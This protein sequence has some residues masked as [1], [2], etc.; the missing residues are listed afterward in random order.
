MSKE[1]KQVQALI[2]E[3]LL[4]QENNYMG[5]PD[6]FSI[7]SNN[8]C[9]R[10]K[11]LINPKMIVPF[12][13][14]HLML[15]LCYGVPIVFNFEVLVKSLSE[16]QDQSAY[17]SW[18]NVNN[19][20]IENKQYDKTQIIT[21]VTI[22]FTLLQ[23]FSTGIIILLNPTTFKAWYKYLCSR[24]GHDEDMEEISCYYDELF[25]AIRDK[26]YPKGK[27]KF[28]TIQRRASSSFGDDDDNDMDFFFDHDEYD[29][30]VNLKHY[31]EEQKARLVE[32]KRR[33]S[34]VNFGPEII[35]IE[36][37][38]H[39]SKRIASRIDGSI[40]FSPTNA[41]YSRLYGDDYFRKEFSNTSNYNSN[42]NDTS[43]AS[44]V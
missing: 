36:Y 39:K 34:I 22:C 6:C 35:S 43:Y 12:F 42:E 33:S 14:M 23:G 8:T 13:I 19:F 24:E 32:G 5:S 10:K 26:L 3:L 30:E 29:D 41:D 21:L 11:K 1:V 44:L 28:N 38:S 16:S 27:N 7:L 17:P 20:D 15:L 31:E 25:E 9:I 4:T 40:A 2:R 18:L 37:E